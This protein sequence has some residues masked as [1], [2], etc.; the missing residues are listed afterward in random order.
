MW[1]YRVTKI[2][3]D[4]VYTARPMVVHFG[5]LITGIIYM[6]FAQAVQNC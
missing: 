5:I 1:G 6:I 3:T 2:Y 4:G